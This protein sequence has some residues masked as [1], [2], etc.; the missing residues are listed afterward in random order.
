MKLLWLG[1]GQGTG[2]W[3]SLSPL[4]PLG[5]G[6]PESSPLMSKL[7]GRKFVNY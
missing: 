1:Q 6:G 4:P 2:S 3:L 7:H 5:G